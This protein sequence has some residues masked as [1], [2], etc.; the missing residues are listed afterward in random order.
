MCMVKYEINYQ[1]ITVFKTIVLL[2]I[3]YKVINVNNF[4][5]TIQNGY[6]FVICFGNHRDF[7]FYLKVQGNV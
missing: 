2:Y 5:L 1:R 3:R 6:V 4:E 7:T